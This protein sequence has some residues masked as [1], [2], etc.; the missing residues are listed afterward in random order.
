MVAGTMTDLAQVPTTEVVVTLEERGRRIH[1]AYERCAID[2]GAELVA[3]KA[4]H[5]GRFMQWVDEMLPFGIDQAER[6]MAITRAFANADAD[7]RAALPSAKSALFE[8]TRLP[9]DRLRQAIEA[10]EVDRTTTTRQARR[11]VSDH[12]NGPVDLPPPSPPPPEVVSPTAEMLAA[13][14]MKQNVDR[15]SGETIV[16]LRRWLG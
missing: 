13:E 2:I 10:G 1:D 14:L 5:P 4:E 3:A 7:T 12:L 6:L 16:R 8:L 15:L 11:L 9:A